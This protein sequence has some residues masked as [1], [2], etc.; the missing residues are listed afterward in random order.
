M[1]QNARENK[2]TL[3]LSKDELSDT[4]VNDSQSYNSTT[5]D[6]TSD[7]MVRS[8]LWLTD[9]DVNRTRNL[10]ILFFF[11]V[12]LSFIGLMKWF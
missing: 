6:P 5:G 1:T 8:L 2:G 4:L 10:L 7:L 11:F 9:R 12:K 3:T